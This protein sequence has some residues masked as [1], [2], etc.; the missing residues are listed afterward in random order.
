MHSNPC[1]TIHSNPCF[2]R[3]VKLAVSFIQLSM[4]CAERVVWV[5]L[6][7]SMVI[8][9]WHVVCVLRS[10]NHSECNSEYLQQ[11]LRI[12][13]ITGCGS[14]VYRLQNK[15]IYTC[16]FDKIH[17]YVLKTWIFK[18]VK[19]SVINIKRTLESYT[20]LLKTSHKQQPA[21]SWT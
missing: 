4:L 18:T 10:L 7:L 6:V 11:G 1:P 14:A 16:I 19:H 9:L 5:V 17:R 2:L 20:K 3:C 21:H 15:H 13:Q 8:N 12:Q